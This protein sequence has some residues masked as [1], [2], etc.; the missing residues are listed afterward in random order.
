MPSGCTKGLAGAVGLVPPCPLAPGGSRA[1]WDGG[2]GGARGPASRTNQ[3]VLR[4]EAWSPACQMD[5]AGRVATQ[6]LAV[7]PRGDD[8]GVGQGQG[9]RSPLCG[10]GLVFLS[11]S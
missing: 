5:G 10:K 11:P 9:P 3:E 7:C 2:D 6:L 1:S 8:A 4:S